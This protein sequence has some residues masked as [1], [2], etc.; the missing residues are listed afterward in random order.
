MYTLVQVTVEAS[1]IGSSAAGVASIHKLPA[2]VPGRKPRS[3][4]EEQVL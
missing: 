1:G 3:S 4:E 2:Q